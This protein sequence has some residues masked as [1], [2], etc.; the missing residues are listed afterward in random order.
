M[1]LQKA[2]KNSC[3]SLQVFATPSGEYSFKM[4]AEEMS[5]E[6]DS[7]QGDSSYTIFNVEVPLEPAKMVRAADLSS[8]LPALEKVNLRRILSVMRSS[9]E[10]LA[11]LFLP[12]KPPSNPPSVWKRLQDDILLKLY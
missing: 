5:K 1:F 9:P 8:V 12:L 6:H 7:T 2:T 10:T 4:V 3:S 11:D